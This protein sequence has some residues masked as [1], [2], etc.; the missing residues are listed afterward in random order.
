M[1]VFSPPRILSDFTRISEIEQLRLVSWK[2][3][4][5]NIPVEKLLVTDALDYIS[6]HFI[7]TDRDDKIIAAN[8]I[9]KYEG[10]HIPPYFPLITD[11]DF[12]PQYTIAY[13]SKLIIHP[14]YRKCGIKEMLDEA[15]LL[16]SR[17]NKID[18]GYGL[19]GSHR[20]PDVLAQGFIFIRRLYEGTE[21]FFPFFR[22]ELN[23]MCIQISKFNQNKDLSNTSR[24][25]EEAEV[26]IN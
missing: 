4:L 19:Y 22:R 1:N 25:A 5:G 11:S 10:K 9:T 20:L 16:W 21:C 3:Y 13:Y 8:R 12:E 18:I 14:A 2:R 23:M 17:E 26:G 7:V 6:T 24:S 15:R